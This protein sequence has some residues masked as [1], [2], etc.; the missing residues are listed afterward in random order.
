LK[1]LICILQVTGKGRDDVRT[2]HNVCKCWEFFALPLLPFSCILVALAT[3][4]P[5]EDFDLTV[6][7]EFHKM[8]LTPAINNET[9]DKDDEE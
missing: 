9:K 1:V 4:K 3:P 6:H 8:E 2:E 7:G 5:N